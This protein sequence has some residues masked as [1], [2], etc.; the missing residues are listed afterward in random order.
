[1]R[2]RYAFR[3]KIDTH[4]IIKY[5][6]PCVRAGTLAAVDGWRIVCRRCCGSAKAYLER[7]GVSVSFSENDGALAAPLRG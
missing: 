1:M 4:S 7:L 3:C 6:N 2:L 5:V